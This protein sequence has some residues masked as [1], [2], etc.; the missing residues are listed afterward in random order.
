MWAKVHLPQ[1]NV[2]SSATIGID[3]QLTELNI[4]QWNYYVQKAIFV[5][6]APLSVKGPINSSIGKLKAPIVIDKDIKQKGMDKKSC[7]VASPRKNI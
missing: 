2:K 6:N 1:I 4:Q 5:E 3:N 7:K